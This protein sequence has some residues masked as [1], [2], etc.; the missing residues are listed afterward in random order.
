MEIRGQR[1]KNYEEKKMNSSIRI[2]RFALTSRKDRGFYGGCPD[3]SNRNHRSG[4]VICYG[5]KFMSN[6]LPNFLTADHPSQI[7][8]VWT[9]LIGRGSLSVRGSSSIRFR[10]S[11]AGS[12]FRVNT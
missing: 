1:W 5:D 9:L 4:V 6:F 3:F 12:N 10:K 7:G 2:A 8:R 11:S